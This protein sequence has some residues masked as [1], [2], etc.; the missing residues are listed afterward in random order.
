MAK[1]L[2][3]HS[4]TLPSCSSLHNSWCTAAPR[5]A[6]NNFVARCALKPWKRKPLTT[7]R[8]GAQEAAEL[9]TIISG[10]LPSG[11]EDALPTFTPED[12]A[13]AT[14]L[15]SQTMLNALANVLPGARA[16]R[17]RPCRAGSR[18]SLVCVEVCTEKTVM[19]RE[20]RNPLHLVPW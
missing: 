7:L 5:T 3:H 13:L 10:E 1:I 17:C 15:H 11:W 16:C 9:N 14:R 19:G 18:G 12:K 4:A 20:E 6:K 8:A 2:H